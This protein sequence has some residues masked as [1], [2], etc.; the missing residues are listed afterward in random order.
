MNKVL[1]AKTLLLI[2][3]SSS[4][5]AQSSKFNLGIEGGAGISKVGALYDSGLGY[6]GQIFGQYNITKIFSAQLGFGYEQKN[7]NDQ[8]T[9]TDNFGN[10]LYNMK[11]SQNF[12]FLTL[13]VLVRAKFGSK[14]NY[15]VNAGPY[16]GYLLKQYSQTNDSNNN[17]SNEIDNASNFKR[18]ETGLSLG[19][20]ISLPLK[21]KLAL[22]FEV[23]DN[24]GLTNLSKTEGATL[25][26]NSTHLLLGLSYSL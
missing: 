10:P 18:F 11:I 7:G 22:S 21:E 13:P 6:T 2:I 12:D 15:F 16:F 5:Y 25:K 26:T 3:F 4:I 1:I 23:R 14:I 24:L 19:I 17:S 9:V 8:I 20:G